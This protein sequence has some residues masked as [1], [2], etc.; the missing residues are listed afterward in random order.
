MEVR[1][2]SKVLR[3]EFGIRVWDMVL[4]SRL[5]QHKEFLKLE[6]QKILKV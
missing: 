5:S 3:M 6:S 1:N 4:T 2:V